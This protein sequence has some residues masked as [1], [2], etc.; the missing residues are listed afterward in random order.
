MEL[1]ILETHLVEDPTFYRNLASKH[2]GALKVLNRVEI[3][4]LHLCGL[5]CVYCYH[6]RIAHVDSPRNS[7]E[8]VDLYFF[9]C[10]DPHFFQKLG[11]LQRFLVDSKVEFKKKTVSIF[12]STDYSPDSINEILT[13][14]FK[15][16]GTK[17]SICACQRYRYEREPASFGD[18]ASSLG[19]QR[20][21]RN[22]PFT[23]R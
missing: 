23:G 7:S 1:Y 22:F 18:G 12:C 19:K 2:F 16:K 14:F 6:K 3:Q 15:T 9:H 17:S 8:N 13:E 4:K 5:Y 10:S 20:R 11:S 21:T